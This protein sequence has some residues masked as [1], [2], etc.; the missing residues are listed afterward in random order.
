MRGE[1]YEIGE[2]EGRKEA[3]SL[4]LR[5]VPWPLYGLL[6]IAPQGSG[7]ATRPS[8]KKAKMPVILLV[9]IIFAFNGKILG[10]TVV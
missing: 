4:L 8:Q 9:G 2:R 5:S 6:T 3:S 1:G 10:N 7:K